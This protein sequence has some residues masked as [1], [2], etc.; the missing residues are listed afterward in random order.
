MS[1]L[2]HILSKN[3]NN[4]LKLN[5]S[6]VLIFFL[7]CSEEYKMGI[8]AKVLFPRLRH[9]MVNVSTKNHLEVGKE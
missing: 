6:G 1:G 5:I 8:V 7:K 4:S 3:V 2:P 9:T